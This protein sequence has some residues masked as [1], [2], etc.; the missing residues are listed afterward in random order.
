[1]SRP[2]AQYIK[3]HADYYDNAQNITYNTDDTHV[4]CIYMLSSP[5]YPI[6]VEDPDQYVGMWIY[7]P[8]YKTSDGQTW[9][10]HFPGVDSSVVFDPCP[11]VSTSIPRQGFSG[12]VAKSMSMT[13]NRTV[14]YIIVQLQ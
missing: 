10:A 11:G 12:R 2:T 4:A 8:T 3:S 7:A 1:M 9:R 13:Q 5:K 14:G 6:R